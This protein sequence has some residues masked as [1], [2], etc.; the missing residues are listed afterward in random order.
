MLK[1]IT[2]VAATFGLSVGIIST[3]G[4][5]EIVQPSIPIQGNILNETTSIITPYNLTK[6]YSENQ[7]YTKNQYPNQGSIPTSYVKTIN[8]ARG[9]WVG[10]LYLSSVTVTS[11]GYNVI[12]TGTL[13]L[14]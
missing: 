5:E 7:Y 11:G 2:T 9:V 10:T 3:A 12:Y 8:D 13:T 6:T 14:Y 1:K 4:A